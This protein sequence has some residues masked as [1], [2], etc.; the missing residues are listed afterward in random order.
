MVSSLLIYIYIQYAYI[1][2]KYNSSHCGYA[3]M[4]VT[5]FVHRTAQYKDKYTEIKI[6]GHLLSYN[7]YNYSDTELILH[8]SVQGGASSQ[9]R[10]N[11]SYIQY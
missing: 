4:I 1:F 2:N 3:S 7:M 10:E 8:I 9:A 11:L 5:I 6:K